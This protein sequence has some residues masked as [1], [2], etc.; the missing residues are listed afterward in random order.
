MPELPEVETI[1]RELRQHLAGEIIADIV[2]EDE[3]LVGY[4]EETGE[5]IRGISGREIEDVRRRG[6]YILIMLSGEK[7]LV[8]HLRMTGKL[9]L[10]K[11]GAAIDK[12]THVIFHL[13]DDGELH[14]N[15]LRKFGR[16]YLV[17]SD[18]YAPVGGLACLGPEPLSEDF[19]LEKFREMLEGRRA[20]IKSLLLKQSFLAGLG[21][22]YTDEA[23]FL[24][25][26]HP[27]RKADQ[28]T[29]GEIEKL[30]TAIK[31]VLT[32][33]IKYRGT[34][35]SDYVNTMGGEGDFQHRLQVY[36]RVGEE[37]FRCGG[38]IEKEKIA[39]RGTHFCP[40][41]QE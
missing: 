36:Q 8:I 27:A 11:A 17:A 4:P 24:A 18:D 19:T 41:C 16:V 12:H 32:R 13:K 34:S 14:F 25:G 26:I 7:T 3:R 1:V 29:G 21:N 9:L 22:I 15:N 2:V 33:G 20:V 6:K 39:G 5:F 37:C 10:K 28:L 38:E 23:L 31:E 35:F 40:H 30:Y